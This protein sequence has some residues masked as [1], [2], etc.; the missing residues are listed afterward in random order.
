[1]DNLIYLPEITESNSVIKKV[2]LHWLVKDEAKAVLDAAL[3][4]WRYYHE[5]PNANPNATYYDIRE[6][7]CGRNE[8]SGN[9]NAK[10]TD[11]KYNQLHEALRKAHKEL[12]KHI[13][14]M[15]YQYEFLIK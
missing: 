1:M 10:S 7:F 14:P 3:P 8:K 2:K 9:M 4:L 15:I 6:Y 13:E 11:E 12:G 5:Q